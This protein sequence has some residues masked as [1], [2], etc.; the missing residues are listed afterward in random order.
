MVFFVSS[1]VDL[2]RFNGC[3]AL[4]RPST[5]EIRQSKIALEEYDDT[6]EGRCF[7]WTEQVE[8]NDQEHTVRK[9]KEQE[10]DA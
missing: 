10:R 9:A 1:F 2:L 4:Y 8:T 5:E 7:A 6:K 3:A